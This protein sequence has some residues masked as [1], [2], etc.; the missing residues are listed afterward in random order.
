MLTP[1]SKELLKTLK[2]SAHGRALREL[3]DEHL[4]KL[5]D[6]STV[7]SWD[8]TLGRKHAKKLIMEIFSFM[9]V[10]KKTDKTPNQY[11]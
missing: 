9:D 4:E 1:Q 7:N 2:T 5:D 11:T 6:I 3:I 10:E 8:E